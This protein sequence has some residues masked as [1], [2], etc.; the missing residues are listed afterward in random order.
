MNRAQ[1]A[2][3]NA[4]GAT[5][6]IAGL[7]AVTPEE[8]D[9]RV[10]VESVRL[11][12]E[13]GTKIVQYRSKF[14][15]RALRGAQ[16]K[17]LLELCREAGAA[18]IVNDDLGLALS[19]KADGLHVGRDDIGVDRAR[20]ALGQSGIL[21]VSCYDS[22]DLA[23]V[24]CGKGANYVAF[25][26]TFPSPTKPAAVHA[27]LAL[28]RQAREM[29]DIP[30]VAIGGITPENASGVIDAGADAVAVVSALFGAADI[31]ATA[32]AFHCLFKRE[33]T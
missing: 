18:F 31:R 4:R 28:F 26:S 20:E 27:P 11:A 8:P 10:L 22:L 5:R 21:G 32:S 17:A 23:I 16:A 1:P 30:I 24:A 7:Y 33:S 19:V 6:R 2:P 13:G 3:E 29:L 9:T 15:G 12:L 14:S 25:G